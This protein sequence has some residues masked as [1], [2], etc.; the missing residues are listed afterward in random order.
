M[1]SEISSERRSDRIAQR[2]G[3]RNP[4]FHDRESDVVGA[5]D[6]AHIDQ[7]GTKNTDQMIEVSDTVSLHSDSED[8]V[9][10]KNQ[11]EE[12]SSAEKDK[13]TEH[14]EAKSDDSEGNKASKLLLLSTVESEPNKVLFDSTTATQSDMHSQTNPQFHLKKYIEEQAEVLL[15]LQTK[16]KGHEDVSAE[17]FKFLQEQT[18]AIAAHTQCIRDIHKQLQSQERAFTTH[19]KQTET[20]TSFVKDMHMEQSK[21][22][23]AFTNFLKGMRTEQS[24]QMEVI[25]KLNGDVMKQAKA[26][27]DINTKFDAWTQEKSVELDTVMQEKFAKIEEANQSL[28]TKVDYIHQKLNASFEKKY[29]QLCSE[30]NA[31]RQGQLAQTEI[32]NNEFSERLDHI[33]QKLS[34]TIADGSKNKS[35]SNDRLSMDIDEMHQNKN[36]KLL[37]ESPPHTTNSTGIK[38]KHY[39]SVSGRAVKKIVSVDSSDSEGEEEYENRV[40]SSDDEGYTKTTRQANYK[41]VKLPPFT[42]KE[43]WDVWFN[44]F[45]A[46]AGRRGWSVEDKLDELL[47]RLQGVA[48]DFVYSQLG[49]KTRSSYR[50]LTKELGARFKQ[51]ELSKTYQAQFS[52][53]VQKSSESVEEFAVDL[54]RLYDKGHASRPLAIRQ[55]DLLRRFL[56]GLA[57]RKVAHQ[58]EFVKE[59]TTLEEAVVEVV[60]YHESTKR[61]KASENERKQVYM[62]RPIDDDEEEE[63]DSD[64]EEQRV[65]RVP[66]KSVKQNA[67]TPPK[68]THSNAEFQTL[69]KS[70][71]DQQ[72]SIEAVAEQQKVLAS[73]MTNISS[74][75]SGNQQ[76]STDDSNKPKVWNNTNRNN[77][78][79]NKGSQHNSSRNHT[80][81]TCYSCGQVGHFARDCSNTQGYSPY[82]PMYNATAPKYVQQ[83]TSVNFPSQ[84]SYPQAP[85]AGGPVLNNPVNGGMS[86]PPP[87]TFVSGNL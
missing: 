83:P 13:E 46:V 19:S 31:V 84:S 16:G 69:L 71:A 21:Q 81:R 3:W 75:S 63:S 34:T 54:K 68:P 36:T 23:D 57:D 87:A 14:S 42:G 6:A 27:T 60:S 37:K 22:T 9:E 8:S 18:G 80:P 64:S 52:K 15:E 85:G 35:G 39:K 58:V 11:M 10:D 43:K 24:Q 55:E 74:N 20:L 26:V 28:D 86:V 79:F 49:E 73:T 78:G 33:Q 32:V 7:E 72:K 30:L 62:V 4:L 5:G 82:V 70:L 76:R 44:R 77:R 45:E 12:V 47:P 61:G 17:Q 40:N 59:P 50:K 65:A 1:D 38:H 48:G 67:H 25:L 2:G 29:D 66:E 51:I 53:R 41:N 56:D